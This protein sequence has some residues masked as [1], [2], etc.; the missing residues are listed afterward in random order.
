MPRSLSG[1]PLAAIQANRVATAWFVKLEI[2]AG[3]FVY[4]TDRPTDFVDS[5]GLITAS[6]AI[7]DLTTWSAYDVVVASVVQNQTSPLDISY[8]EIGNLNNVWSTYLLST[9]TRFRNVW[10]YFAW[11]DPDTDALLGSMKMFEGK[12]DE[13]TIGTRIHIALVPHRT[14]WNALLP[15]RRYLPT[16]Q[17]LF[18]DPDTCANSGTDL[19]CARTLAACGSHN[20]GNSATQ[21][22]RFGGFVLLPPAG[23]KLV[24]GGV[25]VYT[26]VQSSIYTEPWYDVTGREDLTARTE[27]PARPSTRV[28]TR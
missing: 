22:A 1:V 24:W 12:T 25:T 28:V 15:A 23:F 4:Y 16:C 9:G 5:S 13:A 6:E 17:Y 7:P 2:P 27:Q 14:S 18:K 8:I 11:F 3:T 20:G 19:T 10:I 21:V 26:Q